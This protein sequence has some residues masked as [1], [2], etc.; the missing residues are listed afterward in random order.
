VEKKK[1]SFFLFF[2]LWGNKDNLERGTKMLN[3]TFFVSKIFEGKD[4]FFVYLS[5]RESNE[6]KQVKKL[7]PTY[8]YHTL[9]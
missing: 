2:F 4:L 6:R 9:F 7:D 5:F 8:S 1:S 3:P